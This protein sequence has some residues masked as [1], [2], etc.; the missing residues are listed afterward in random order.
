[1]VKLGTLFIFWLIFNLIIA[2]YEI[3]I[4]QNRRALQLLNG[5][6]WNKWL[7]DGNTSNFLLDAWSEYC[8]V[9]LRYLED[10][11]QYV[12]GFEILNAVSAIVLAVLVIC[13]W[14][15]TS[16]K[17]IIVSQLVNCVAYFATLAL[18]YFRGRSVTSH[19]V[20]WWMFGLYYAISSIWILIPGIII[21]NL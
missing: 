10:W 17:W 6:V 15:A 11:G 13:G 19:S 4:F 18:E 14:V 2:I 8:N 1:M 12:W 5:T 20:E 21:M 16:W 7:I 3:F 9:D